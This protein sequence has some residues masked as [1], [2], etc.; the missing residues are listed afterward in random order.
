M[1]S[2]YAG[3]LGTFACRSN[4]APRTSLGRSDLSTV[5]EF[6]TL[7]Q[8]VGPGLGA[9]GRLTGA[10]ARSGTSWLPSL[11]GADLNIMSERPYSRAKFHAVAVVRLAGSRVVPVTLV[12]ETSVCRPSC[13]EGLTTL[14]DASI[15]AA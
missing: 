4:A 5:V 10:S 15:E 1:R 14:V 8:L 12:G 11:P 13:Q 9:I 6:H 7:T 3:P 2:Q